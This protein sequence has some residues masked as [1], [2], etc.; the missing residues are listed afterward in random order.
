MNDGQTANI[1]KSVKLDKM[2]TDGSLDGPIS[3]FIKQ[4]IDMVCL[5][6]GEDTLPAKLETI[7]V[8][9]T[10]AHYVQ[11]MNDAD[12]VKSY[13]EEGASWSFNDNELGPY[14]TLLEKYISD[15]DGQGFKGRV[16]SW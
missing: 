8:R 7:V 10:E 15:R 5:Y 12:G 11:S 2:I 9:I 13:S 14:T 4:A 1:L 6:V 3:N 16:M